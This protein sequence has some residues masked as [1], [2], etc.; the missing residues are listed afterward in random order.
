MGRVTVPAEPEAIEDLLYVL[1]VLP[2]LRSASPDRAVE[3]VAGLR[4]AGLQVIEL[5]TSTPDWATALVDAGTRWPDLCV[6]VGT[7]TTTT[8]AE[9]A[10]AAG[11]RFLVSP[12][13]APAVRPIAAEAGIPFLEGG[14]SPGEIADAASRG[15]AKLFPAHV[16]G[17]TYVRSLLAVLPLARIIPTGG[18][19]LSQVADYLAAGAIAVGVG[20]ALLDEPDLAGSLAA[21]TRGPGGTA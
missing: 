4:T 5:T 18:V 14:F 2:V 13:P 21:L 12:W 7:V 8:Q 20:S 1:P 15:P 6:G 19:R 16:G 10:V 3:D 11:A 17:P 9:A